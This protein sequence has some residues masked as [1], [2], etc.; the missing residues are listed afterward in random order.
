MLSWMPVKSNDWSDMSSEFPDTN[1]ADHI[2]QSD[3]VVLAGLH[4]V[5]LALAE[6]NP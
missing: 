2:I 4:D 3:M 5:A 6:L 1:L